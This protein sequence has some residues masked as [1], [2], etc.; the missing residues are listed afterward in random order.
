[1]AN[2]IIHGN[3]QLTPTLKTFAEQKLAKIK[4]LTERFNSGLTIRL[5]L[6]RKTAHHR[7][8][9]VFYAEINCDIPGIGVLR[10]QATEEDIRIALNLA[11]EEMIRQIKDLKGRLSEKYKKGAR[12]FKKQIRNI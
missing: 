4:R 1:M 9:R 12:E 3:I 5:E 11:V 6:S 2:Q 8:G 7:K 10:S